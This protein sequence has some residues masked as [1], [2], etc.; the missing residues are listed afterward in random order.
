[1]L[2]GTAAAG[3]ALL[4]PARVRAAEPAPRSGGTLRVSM[5][6]N[7]AALDPMTGRNLPDFNTLYAVF[8]ALIDY[9]PPTLN[10]KPGLAKAWRFTDPKTLVLDLVDGVE[11]HDGTPF[12]AAAAKFNIDRYLT[13]PRSNVKSDLNTVAGCDVTG[14]SQITIR[15]NRPN[16]GMPAILTNRCGLMVSPASV[17]AAKGGNV[18]RNPVG[19][20]PFKFVSWQDNDKITLTKNTNYWKSG[21]PYL[22]GLELHI[23]SELN[24]VA[25]TVIAG[26]AEVALNVAVT[27]KLVADKVPSVVSVVDP[28]LTFFGAFLNYGQGPL[29]DVRIR[30]AMNWA[31]DRDVIN[32]IINHGLGET[33]SAI[34]SRS[35]WACDPKTAGHYTHDPE[36]AKK[37]LADAGHANGIE[38]PGW[39]WPDQ[40]SMQRQELIVNQLAEV[41][42]RVKVQPASP[43]QAM[44]GFMV[45]QQ[46]SL[47]ISP[48][49]ALPD[50][51]QAY[52]R[53]F[54][55]DALRN[56]G[57]V[58]LPG[59]RPLM[60]AT[61]AAQSQDERKEAFAKLQAFVIEQAMELPQYMAPAITIASRKVKGYVDGLLGTPKFTTVWLEA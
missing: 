39:G 5:P 29:T 54:A 32:Q 38:V 42:I 6:Y 18:D 23:I 30:Q 48:Q 53:L 51:S 3:G 57:R 1:L 61:T 25:R 16:S 24:T 40:A 19:A 56:A 37:L 9:D 22:S 35:F 14:K 45:K 15:L 55:K 12:D 31:I 52:E 7:P 21:L 11:F 44:E 60:D 50:P 4:L 2:K 46:R 43:P 41:G 8:D 26:Q 59:F 27:Q 33:T 34:L 49:G 47:L 10:L 58:E 13:D 36:R 20:G 17:K 28:S